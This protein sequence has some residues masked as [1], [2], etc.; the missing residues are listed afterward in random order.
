MSVLLGAAR[1]DENNDILGKTKGDQTT[2]EV[3]LHNWYDHEWQYVL[4]P[5]KQEIA[6]KTAK[7]MEAA[8]AN[9]YIGYSQKN[10]LEL[11]YLA[12]ANGFNLNAIK[13]PCDCDCSS[14][15]AVCAIGAG[16]HVSPD[17][18][19]GNEMQ[20]FRDSGEYEVITK[21]EYLRQSCYLKRGDILVTPYSHTAMVLTNGSKVANGSADKNNFV[22]P[23]KSRNNDYAGIYKATTDVYIRR[24]AGK[25]FKAVA[26]LKEGEVC[27]N[28]GYF[29][30]SGSTTWLY[31]RRMDI[32]GYISAKYLTK[33]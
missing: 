30:R 32:V 33:I 19:T 1:I 23:A 12:K 6:D 26:V 4:R 9:N 17:L 5:I 13:T 15:I 7:I 31:I 27:R 16:V 25:Q 20:Q 28:Y 2:H 14:L 29:T 21:Q 10:R 11:Y 24:G 3:E 8:C 22:D 18:Y